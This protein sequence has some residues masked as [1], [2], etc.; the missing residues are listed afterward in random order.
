MIDGNGK[1]GAYTAYQNFIKQYPMT[2]LVSP[3]NGAN[4]AS[5]PT[6]V[7]TPVNGAARYRLEVSL[8]SNFSSTVDSVTTDNTRY[9]PTK[10]YAPQKTYYWRVAIVDGD[11]KLGPFVGDWMIVDTIAPD[12]TITGHPANPSNS[13]SAAFTFSSEDGTATFECSL[14]GGAYVTCSSEK[15][16]TGLSDGSHTFAVRAKDPAGNV[17]ATPASYTWT[18]DTTAPDTTITGHP[19]NPDNDRT[20]TFTF[21][22]DDGPTGSGIAS[23]MCKMDSSI[24]TACTS[25]FTS[26]ALSEGSH[27]FYVYAIDNLG[28][29]DASPASYPWTVDATAPG[30]TITGHPAN[31]SNSTSAG[32]TFSSADG[33]A[34]FECSLDGSAYAA[35]SSEKNYTG[36][37][38]GSHTFA[39]R[40]KDPAGNVDATPASYPWTV[41]ATAPDTTITGHPANPDNDSTPTFTFSG[42]DGPTG[43]GIASFMCK[44]DSGIY[45]AC[46]SP[47]TS[48]A[49]SGGSHTF[50]A[51]A[52]DNLGNA[53]VSP[54]SYTWTIGT[55]YQIFLPLVV[56]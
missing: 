54:A 28:N 8:Y 5:T 9:T 19:A 25:P 2:D 22:G 38:D 10:T 37:S 17:D 34:T 50:Y 23:F 56:R 31:P 51:Y 26:S 7:W 30:T 4:L 29:A 14:D 18:V 43:S 24:Y 52:I 3:T 47:F 48:S 1:A 33:T 15:N 40:A 20:S 6:F 32:F 55:T 13:T 16:Y 46:T 39:V 42:D 53:D 41:D 12:T 11:G 49:L 45:A 35:C 36:L 27:T 21:S 44:M